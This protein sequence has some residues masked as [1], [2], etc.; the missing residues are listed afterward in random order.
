[1]GRRFF[2]ICKYPFRN[3]SEGDK[4][5]IG[6]GYLRFASILFLNI[7]EEDKQKIWP[8]FLRFV[9]ILFSNI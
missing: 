9:S 2:M 1:M 5:K 8:R 6:P 3:I 7:S 4:Q